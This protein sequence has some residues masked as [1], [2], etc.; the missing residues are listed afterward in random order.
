[1][2]VFLFFLIHL[3]TEFTGSALPFFRPLPLQFQVNIILWGG[4]LSKCSN[5]GNPKDKYP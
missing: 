5:I 2:D 3:F 1:M 4:H